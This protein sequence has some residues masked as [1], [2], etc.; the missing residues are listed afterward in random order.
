MPMCP[1]AEMCRGMMRRPLSNVT[2]MIP[3]I[4]LIAL[5]ILIVLE[6]RILA[7]LIAVAF[8]LIG[9]MSFM[10]ARFVRRMG[11]RFGDTD[12]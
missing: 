6:P 4:V 2:L 11:A 8:I 7:W 10:M 1:M 12:R 9:V 5:G 3:G